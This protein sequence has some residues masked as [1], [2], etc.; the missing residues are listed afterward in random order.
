SFRRGLH[1]AAIFND[2]R[3]NAFTAGDGGG[4]L[5]TGA[6]I[7]GVIDGGSTFPGLFAV[8]PG[9]DRHSGSSGNAAFGA[10]DMQTGRDHVP[11]T[12]TV[13]YKNNLALETRSPVGTDVELAFGPAVS[14]RMRETHGVFAPALSCRNI[15]GKSCDTINNRGIA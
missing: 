4:Q 11:R 5:E 1:C 14:R 7:A 8:D 15:P 9:T 10:F 3:D 13:T 12:V 6:G 2:H